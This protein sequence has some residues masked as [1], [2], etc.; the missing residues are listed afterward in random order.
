MKPSKRR[1]PI[2]KFDVGDPGT[3][4]EYLAACNAALVKLK[5]SLYPS[6]IEIM[7][8]INETR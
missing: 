8:T 3:A 4:A 2:F 1:E 6:H 5:N 7:P